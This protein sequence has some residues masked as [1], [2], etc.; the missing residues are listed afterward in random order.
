[1]RSTLSEIY[2]SS[3]CHYAH[4]NERLTN[5]LAETREITNALRSSKGFAEAK[6]E[7]DLQGELVGLLQRKNK[8]VSPSS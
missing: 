5:V 3:A 4:D 6:R 1:M 2:F 8:A 7:R